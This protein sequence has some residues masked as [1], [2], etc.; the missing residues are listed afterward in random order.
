[1][2]DGKCAIGSGARVWLRPVPVGR[3]RVTIGRLVVMEVVAD[4]NRSNYLLDLQQ[5]LWPAASVL[6]VPEGS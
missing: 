5:Q 4:E 3:P 2:L 6:C 1:M